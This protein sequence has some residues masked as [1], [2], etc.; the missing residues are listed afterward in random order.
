MYNTIRWHTGLT[1]AM[2][3]TAVTLYKI[4]FWRLD[5]PLFSSQATVK[6][7]FSHCL[8]TYE[9]LP[10]EK[11]SEWHYKTRC[12]SIHTSEQKF[13]IS[14]IVNISCLYESYMHTSSFHRFIILMVEL[15][16]SFVDLLWHMGTCSLMWR[17]FQNYDTY[18]IPVS[19]NG[20]VCLCNPSATASV[21]SGAETITPCY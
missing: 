6:H 5:P 2:R 8:W 20:Q 10:W 15:I 9:S 11:S 4:F 14:H 16:M 1:G 17:L 19:V 18:H 13:K 7:S 21:G 12:V 3:P